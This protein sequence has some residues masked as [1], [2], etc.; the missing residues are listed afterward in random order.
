VFTNGQVL[1]QLRSKDMVY[2]DQLNKSG[3]AKVEVKNV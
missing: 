1:G 2:L 3:V